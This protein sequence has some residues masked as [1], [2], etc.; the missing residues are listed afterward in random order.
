M[1]SGKRIDLNPLF[2]SYLKSK[3]FPPKEGGSPFQQLHGAV[4]RVSVT[5]FQNDLGLEGTL[6]IIHPCH[7]QGFWGFCRKL[8][9]LLAA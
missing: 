2:S 6:K 5:E 8:T 1:P 3:Y 4:F 7:G 9:V